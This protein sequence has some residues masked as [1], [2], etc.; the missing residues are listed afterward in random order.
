VSES[1]SS[2]V[3]ASPD[4]SLARCGGRGGRGSSESGWW[5]KWYGLIR[6]GDAFPVKEC[7]RRGN[8]DRCRLKSTKKRERERREND[9]GCEVDVNEVKMLAL[10]RL[11]TTDDDC[12][13][14]RH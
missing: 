2:S 10:V 7:V 5:I 3:A 9:D 11:L 12:A 6:G 8:E 4:A 1:P 14:P 13:P